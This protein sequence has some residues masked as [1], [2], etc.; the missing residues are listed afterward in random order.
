MADYPYGLSAEL[1]PAQCAQLEATPVSLGQDVTLNAAVVIVG[2]AEHVTRLHAERVY[3]RAEHR[4]YWNPHDYV[5]ALLLRRFAAWALDLLDADLRA[6]ATQAVGR[7]DD[8]LRSF[9]EPD[10][11]GVVR[12]FS[13]DDADTDSQEWWWGRIP[14]SGPVREELESWWVRISTPGPVPEELGQ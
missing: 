7:F 14:T 6:S 5:A 10:E 13:P 11:R 4:D 1:G 12:R 2:W 3:I 9:T 8:L